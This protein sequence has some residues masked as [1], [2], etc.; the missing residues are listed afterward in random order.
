MMCTNREQEVETGT[1]REDG[2]KVA[3][4]GEVSK[5]AAG[6]PIQLCFFTEQFVSYHRQQNITASGFGIPL[7]VY[8]Q[9]TRDAISK[10]SVSL[11]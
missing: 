8:A 6:V 9:L 7:R 1:S 4:D 5:I 3:E 11:K 10:L 2:D